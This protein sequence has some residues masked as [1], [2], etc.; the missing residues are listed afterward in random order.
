[1]KII[2]NE[3]TYK[4]LTEENEELIN[5]NSSYQIP[6]DLFTWMG[7][8]YSRVKDNKKYTTL[9]GYKRLQNYINN[10]G[11]LSYNWLRRVKNFFDNYN[12]DENDIVYLMNGGRGMKRWVN[13]T[14]DSMTGRVEASKEIDRI[15]NR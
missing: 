9:D 13:H 5:S 2:I 11:F 1:M 6:K 8:L 12:G 14:L 3:N 15:Y 7:E 4:R 10:D